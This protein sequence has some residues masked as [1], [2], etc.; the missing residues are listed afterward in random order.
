MYRRVPLW[1]VCLEMISSTRLSDQAVVLILK[2][3][4][5]R[6]GFDPRGMAGHSLRAA[7]AT[8]AAATPLHRHSPRCKRAGTACASDSANG[9]RSTHPCRRAWLPS[10]RLPRTVEEELRRR[11]RGRPRDRHRGSRQWGRNR[12]PLC[13]RRCPKAS[14]HLSCTGQALTQRSVPEPSVA[15]CAEASPWS[16]RAVPRGHSRWQRWSSTPGSLRP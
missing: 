1:L 6:A 3:H 4:V 5:A 10:V 12:R 13:R 15:S 2:C 14:G 11:R 7:P 16:L 9:P 8:S